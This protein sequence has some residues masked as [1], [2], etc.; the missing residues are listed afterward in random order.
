MARQIKASTRPVSTAPIRTEVRN[1][2]IPRVPTAKTA[3]AAQPVTRE[4]IALRA[5]F[6]SQTSNASEFDNWL[7]AERE[8][9]AGR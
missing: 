1:S 7:R 8:L 6:I 2:P 9:R 5:Y 4:A 3:G